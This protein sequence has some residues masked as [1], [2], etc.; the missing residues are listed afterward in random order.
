MDT[1]IDKDY[2]NELLYR[3][4]KNYDDKELDFL[5]DAY[6]SDV[7]INKYIREDILIC[8]SHGQMPYER[9]MEDF[10]FIIEEIKIGNSA[11][12]N[13]DLLEDFFC[14]YTGSIDE[15]IIQLALTVGHEGIIVA[16]LQHHSVSV[17]LLLDL[18][19]KNDVST[20]PYD[21]VSYVLKVREKEVNAHINTM[22]NHQETN[23]DGLPKSWK[24][25]AAGHD[26]LDNILD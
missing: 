10:D 6:T 9:I 11:R 5:W 1:V 23:G 18:G 14:M 15:T 22:L 26:W 4:L 13:S 17:E 24:Y 8:F 2:L 12:L 20:T 25:K 16:A 19:D 7:A 3:M 21:V